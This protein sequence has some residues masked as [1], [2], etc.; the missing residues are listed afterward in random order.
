MPFVIRYPR[1][2]AP[3]TVCHD[4]ASNVDFAP[5]FLD[6]AGLVQP[7][8]MQGR[9]MRTLLQGKT[10][11]DW[12]QIAYHRYWMHRDAIHNA[13]AHYG[14]RTQRYKLVY[15]YNQ[16]LGAPGSQPGGEPPE[17]ELFDCEVD[18][19]ELINCHDDPAYRGTVREMTKLLERTMAN[20]GDEPAHP[21]VGGAA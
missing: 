17:W 16:G 15:W 5:T 20:I 13:Y 10:P 11:P 18:P 12:P 6:L 1:E 2:I 7:S 8:Y 3:G 14:I 9:S 21:L 19:L 4:I